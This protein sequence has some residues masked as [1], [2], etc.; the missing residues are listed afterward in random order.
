MA[1]EYIENRVVTPKIDVYA[2]G[3]VMLE[4]I[5]GKDA[6]I[7]QE[8]REVLLSAA[9][10]SIME[11]DD[12]ETELAY[13]MKDLA[14]SEATQ[15]PTLLPAPSTAHSSNHPIHRQTEGREV[16]LSAAITSIMEGDDAETEL[17]YFMKDLAPSEATQQP[18]LLPAPST[19]H[20]SNHPIHR[21][22]VDS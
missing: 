18:T 11:G 12:A 5:T 2:F 20:S 8:G 22:T 13:F 7:I 19:A 9:I 3:V 21:Q 17:A 6:A 10:T 15:Q 14:P 1:P 16:L 4:L